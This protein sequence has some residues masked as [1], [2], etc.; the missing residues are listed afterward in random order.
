[1]LT[2]T[3]RR[4]MFAKLKPF[5]KNCLCNFGSKLFLNKLLTYFM[6]SICSPMIIYPALR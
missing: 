3:N 2:K 6:N 4:S 1:M 5:S